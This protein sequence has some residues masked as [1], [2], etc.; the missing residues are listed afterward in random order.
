MLPALENRNVEDFDYDPEL[1]G[2]YHTD[3]FNAL[4]KRYDETN[5][6]PSS[7][8]DVME[9]MKDIL[10]NYCPSDDSSQA[11]ECIKTIIKYTDEK[12]FSKLSHKVK[13]TTALEEAINSL[14]YAIRNMDNKEDIL[15]EIDLLKDGYNDYNMEGK[16]IL[17]ALSV[18]SESFKLWHD[19]FEDENHPFHLRLDHGERRLH[20]CT[21]FNEIIEADIAGSAIVFNETDQTENSTV[22]SSTVIFSSVIASVAQFFAGCPD[23]LPPSIWI[24]EPPTMVPSVFS[25]TV[26]TSVPSG[27]PSFT[28][29]PSINPTGTNSPSFAINFDF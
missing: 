17:T 19:V 22:S 13:G 18:G 1:I 9:D 26:P 6:R 4:K 21:K 8:V 15:N 5:G 7:L 24:S 25:S 10:M 11:D 20:V 23:T 12:H 3:A 28:A 27:S 16:M 2:L 29:L 14:D